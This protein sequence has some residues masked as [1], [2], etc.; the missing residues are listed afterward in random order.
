MAYDISLA[1]RIRKVLRGRSKLTEK[2][3]FGG[4]SFMLNGNVACGVIGGEMMVRV[5]PAAHEQAVHQ[6]HARIFD[7]SGRPSK[8]WIMVAPDGLKTDA[9]LKSWVHRGVDFASSLPPK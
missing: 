1:E 4:I 3:A 9:D 6:P 7:F 8:G 5:G 2:Q